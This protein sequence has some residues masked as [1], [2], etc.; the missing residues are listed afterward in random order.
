MT[1]FSER[2]GWTGFEYLLSTGEGYRSHCVLRYRSMALS[3]LP[4]VFRKTFRVN[5][6]D[7]PL[8]RFFRLLTSCPEKGF[9]MIPKTRYSLDGVA[10]GYQL[11]R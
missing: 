7:G 1:R 4:E 2:S 6:F 11:D 3:I 8:D 10:V 5:V 9:T